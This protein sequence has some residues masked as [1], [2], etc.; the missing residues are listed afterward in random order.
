MRFPVPRFNSTRS[1]GKDNKTNDNRQRRVLH[2]CETYPQNHIW[3]TTVLYLL[4]DRSWK[5][6]AVQQDWVNTPHPDCILNVGSPT[7]WHIDTQYSCR[8]TVLVVCR[9]IIYPPTAGVVNYRSGASEKIASLSS[10]AFWLQVPQPL[11]TF[12]NSKGRE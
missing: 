12:A 4:H 3:R 11:A 5:R 9:G 7:V 6:R 2:S 1:G 10:S 8:A